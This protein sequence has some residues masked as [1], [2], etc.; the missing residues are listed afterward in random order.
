MKKLLIA[1]LVGGVLGGCSV[2]H[3]T[4]AQTNVS[5]FDG[6]KQIYSDPAGAQQASLKGGIQPV[7]FGARWTDKVPDQTAVQVEFFHAITNLTNLYLNIDGKIY[8]FD[9]I[10]VS[11]DFKHIHNMK[12]SS[13]EFMV[14][15]S[16][17]KQISAAKEVK[18]KVTTLSDGYR[19]GIIISNG[20]LTP[21]AKSLIN[22]ANQLP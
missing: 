5:S 18:Y 9:P 16:V 7:A 20:K 19:E 22:V 2:D 17:L 8:K 14:P 6:S 10:G 15:V 13:R 11:T 12:I 1:I 4:R 3:M 21:A